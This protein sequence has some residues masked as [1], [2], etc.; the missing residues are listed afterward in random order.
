MADYTARI[1]DICDSLASINVT[2]KEDE[3][4]QVYLGVLMLKFGAFWMGVCTRENTHSFFDFKTMLLVEEKHAGVSKSRHT[5]NRM[6]Y[7]EAERPWGRGRRGG[8]AH[9]GSG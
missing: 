2:V 7:T 1:K 9:G 3:M 4:M 6:L 8:S 5:D